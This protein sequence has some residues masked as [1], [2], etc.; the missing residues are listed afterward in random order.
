MSLLDF[1]R[2]FP[3]FKETKNG[4]KQFAFVHSYLFLA[5]RIAIFDYYDNH[6]VYMFR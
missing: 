3:C 5:S 2:L 6:V 1:F 4:Q